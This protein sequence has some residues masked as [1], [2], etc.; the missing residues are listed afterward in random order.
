MKGVKFERFGGPE[1]LK[2]SEIEEPKSE[3]GYAIVRIKYTSTNRLDTLVRKGY[4]QNIRL[5]HVPGSDV[6][7]VIESISDKD[8]SGFVDGDRVIAHPLISCGLCVECSSGREDICKRWGVIGREENGSYA[9]LVKIRTEQLFHAPKNMSQKEL[10]CLPLALTAAWRGIMLAEPIEGK[11]ILIKGASGNV[12]I[13]STMICKALG[14]HAIAM[15]R[16]GGKAEGL[17]RIGAAFVV[18]STMPECENRIIEYTEGNGVDAVLD[19]LGDIGSSLNVLKT[20]GK[21]ISYGVLKSQKSEIDVSKLYLK[22]GSIIGTHLSTRKEFGEALKFI[23]E[24]GIHPI[25]GMEMDISEADESHRLLE[26]SKPFGKIL[27][28]FD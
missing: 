15:T 20:G 5:P 9:E 12:G 16:G 13:I 6:S 27:L 19:C 1:V 4:V 24:N 23:S 8:K 22:S 2:F 7:G 17:K 25:I 28:S 14:M 26:D 18:D 3:Q 11:K 21:I 10:S